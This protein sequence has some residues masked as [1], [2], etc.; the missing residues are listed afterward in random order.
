MRQHVPIRLGMVGGGAGAMIGNVHRIAARLDN[1]FRLLAGALS[2]TAEKAA[3]SAA[4]AGI[5]RSYDDFHEMARAEAARPDGIE[6]VAICTP[7][8]LHFPVARAFL[9]QGIHVICDKPMTATLEQGREL[10]ELARG[11]DALFVLTHNYSA[12]P[13][14]RQARAMIARGDLGR[15]RLV[16]VEYAQDWLTEESRSKQAEWR[17]DPARAGAGGVIG[18]IGTHAF[19]LARFVTGMR[20][21]RIAADLSSF[22]PGRRLDD[23]AH[24]LMRYANGAKG[25]LWVSQV[26]PGTENGLKLRVYGDKAGLEWAHETPE[27]LWFTRFGQPAQKLRRA[28]PGTAPGLD[29]LSRVPPGHPEGYLEGFGNLYAEAAE[30][31]RA[32][33]AGRPLPGHLALPGIEDGLEGLCFIDACLRSHARD[34]AFVEVMP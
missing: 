20:P 8:H 29:R 34:A 32:R 12:Y 28:G 14:I 19:Q 23:N 25:M 11:S 6:A 16:Q 30:A 7:N 21:E 3:A 27:T 15:L 18:D 2:S 31:I 17:G 26:A 4:E 5:A 10:A 22:V 1:R 9:A 33:Q 13:Q 24:V